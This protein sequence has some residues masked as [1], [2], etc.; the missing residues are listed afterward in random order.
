MIVV[1]DN[2]GA[3]Q[4][5]LYTNC[6]MASANDIML[7]SKL[8]EQILGMWYNEAALSTDQSINYAS[9][10]TP[11]FRDDGTVLQNRLPQSG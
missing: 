1:R 8:R 6:G 5:S 2:D 7:M 10:Y 9:G 4:L 3:A 11:E